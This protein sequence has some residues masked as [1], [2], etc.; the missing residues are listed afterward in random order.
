VRCHEEFETEPKDPVRL[1][2]ADIHFEKGL[3]CHNCHGGDPAVGIDVGTLEDAKSR[4]KGFIGRPGR[5]KV[6]T[7]CASCH[8]NLEFMRRFNPQVRV[9]QYVEYKTSR[10]GK[11]LALGDLNVATCVDCHGAHGIRSV[12]DPKS[13]VYPTNV[14]ET[15]ARCHADSARMVPYKLPTN[16]RDLFRQSVHGQALL[17]NRD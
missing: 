13:S 10:H 11:R 2:R 9:D 5:S 8:S 15:C 17:N 14:A 16:Q 7:L 1:F 3:S 12:H 4:A 6:V